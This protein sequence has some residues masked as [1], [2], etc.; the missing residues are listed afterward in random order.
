M[1]YLSFILFIL[2]NLVSVV[3]SSHTKDEW[4]SRTIYQVLTDRYAGPD[5]NSCDLSNYCG[6]TFRGIIDQL[7][8]I[9]GLGFDAI[10]ISPVVEN[11]PGGYHGYWAQNI[12]AINHQFGSPE[13][14]KDLVAAAHKKDVWVMVD[15][16]A[17]HMGGTI[18]D[19]SNFSPFNEQ[20]HY[21]DCKNCGDTCEIT[22]FDTLYSYN[23]E[24]CR[25]SGLPDLDQDNTWVAQQLLAWVTQLVKE[26][27]FDGIRIDTVPEVK[28]TFW[29]KFTE[30]AGCY[31]VGEV[32]NGDL[33]FVSAYQGPIDG[34]LSYPMYYALRD[35]FIDQGSFADLQS[36]SDQMPSS[37]QDTSVLGT[38][39]DNHDNPRFLS[40]ENDQVKYINALAHVLLSS[41]IPIVYYGTEQGFNGGDDPANREILWP[42]NFDSDTTNNKLLAFLKSAIQVRK[43][44]NVWNLDYPAW[45][46]ADKNFGIFSRGSSILL[47]TTNIGDATGSLTRTVTLN[48]E[49]FSSGNT[50]C[51]AL[52]TSYCITTESTDGN[53]VSLE[54]SLKDGLP[55]IL[56]KDAELGRLK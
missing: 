44:L 15:V 56:V 43:Q 16:V 47:A 2:L 31:S 10:W 35:T 48:P 29:Q 1:A 50:F 30:A 36:L 32:F 7:D 25:L 51:D 37:F 20:D 12:S 45:Y 49:L 28:P 38:F 18:D 34:L 52:E 23:L 13:D 39:L 19:I 6:G 8:Y 42:T 46:L 55:R 4:Q 3:V 27:N 53:D 24:H 33:D 22:D 9:I 40:I 26:Y 17:N 41:G 11:T 5:S 54:V 21:H 14:L